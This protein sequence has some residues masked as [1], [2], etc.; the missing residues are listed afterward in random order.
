MSLKKNN[1]YPQLLMCLACPDWKEEVSKWKKDNTYNY[2][3]LITS[4]F[5]NYL[6]KSLKILTKLRFSHVNNST[7]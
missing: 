7:L 6:I 2:K 1:K 5:H 4:F 3:K